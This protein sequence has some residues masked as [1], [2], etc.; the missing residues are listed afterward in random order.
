MICPFGTYSF[1]GSTTCIPC[2]AGYIC[3]EGST[4]PSPSTGECPAGGWCDGNQ[5]HPCESG[6][7]NNVSMPN[8]TIGQLRTRPEVCLDCLVGY[9]CTGPGT[10]N[11]FDYSCPAGHYCPVGTKFPTQFP[12]S[13]G[14]YN[15]NTTQTSLEAGCLPNQCP[16]GFYCPRGTVNPIICPQ[17]YYCPLGT[18]NGFQHACPLG[19]YGVFMYYENGT[20][21]Y[22]LSSVEDCIICPP[23]FYCPDGSGDNP[24]TAPVPCPP[25]T[26]NPFSGTG[27]PF[28]CLTCTPGFSCPQANQTNVTV[29]CDEGHYCPNGTVSSSQYPCPPGTFT[30]S[31]SLTSPEEC[32]ICPPGKSCGWATGL[33]VNIWLDCNPGHYCPS[34]T[35]SPDKFPCPPG[36]YT[37][38]SNLTA[39]EECSICPETKYCVGG[40]PQPDALCPPG[41]YCPEGTRLVHEF[42]CPATMY[43]PHFGK[44]QE[45][46]C[47]NCTQGHFCEEA[48]VRPLDCPSG[49]Y[50]PFGVNDNNETVGT[51]AGKQSDCLPCLAGHFCVNG[52]VNPRECGT[53][54]YTPVGQS[55]CI[56]CPSGH[57]CDSNTTTENDLQTAKLCP[58][59]KYCSGSLKTVDDALPCS[60]G[61]FCPE[62]IAYELPCPVGT[63]NPNTGASSLDDCLPCTAGFYCLENS[64]EVSGPCD[65]GFYCPVNITNGQSDKLIGSYGPQQVPCPQGTYQSNYSSA[66][67]GDCI[68][69]PAGSYCPVGSAEPLDCPRGYYCGEAVGEPEPCPIGTLGNRTGLMW[70]EDC[71]NCTKGRFCDAPGLP[72]P[73]GPCD[74][75]YLCYGGAYT[76][77]PTDGVTGEICPRGGYCPLGSFQSKP[78]PPGTFNNNS[79][80][81][82]FFDC[83]ECTPG[84]YCSDA[85]GPE[86]T[87]PC[88][89]GFYCTGG[90]QTARQHVAEPGFFAPSGSANQVSCPL[91]TY[92]PFW[93]ASKCLDCAVGHYCPNVSMTEPFKCPVGH[94][95]PEGTEEPQRCPPGTYSGVLLLA[96]ADN[97]TKC[98]A[99][100]F[101]QSGG[102]AAPEG[103][104][105][106]GHICRGGSITATP[107]VTPDTP[108]ELHINDICSPGFYCPNGTSFEVPCP[109]GTYSEAHALYNKTQCKPCLPGFYCPKSNMSVEGDL[110][111]CDPGF[112]CTLGSSVSRPLDGITGDI[113]SPG[114]YCPLGSA[115][116]LICP[117][118]TYANDSGL[119][120]CLICPEGLYCIADVID[121][122]PCPIGY[123][124]GEQTG[125]NY[126]PCPSGT[127]GATDSLVRETDCTICPGGMYCEFPAQ[128][129]TTGECD[130]GFWCREGARSARPP[131]HVEGHYGVCPAGYY[132]LQGSVGPEPCHPGF[133][134]PS[135]QKTNADDCIACDSGRYCAEGNQAEPTGNC[136]AGWY[137]SEGSSESQPGNFAFNE[138]SGDEEVVINVEYGGRCPLGFYCPEGSS[139]PLQCLPGTYSSR[140]GNEECIECPGGY[141]CPGETV[142]P[143]D[144]PCP[145]GYYCLNGTNTSTQYP[146]PV[147][148]FN[149]LTTRSSSRDCVTCTPG[150]YCQT[151][152]LSYPT[153]EC[154]GGVY[155]PAG[156]SSPTGRTCRAGRYCPPRSSEERPCIA[157]QFC[158]GNGN[159]APTGN[160][161][162]GYYCVEGSRSSRPSNGHC[163][164]GSYCPEGS[165][166]PTPCPPGTFA[167]ETLNQN[168][169]DCNTCLQG[170][171]CSGYDNTDVDGPCTEGYYCPPGQTQAAPNEF[172]CP[173]GHFCLQQ[174]SEPVR[175][176]SGYYQNETGQ[177]SCRKC[178]SGYY[179]DNS[180]EPI[181]FYGEFICPPGYYCEEGTEY[182]TQHPCPVGTFSNKTGL[183]HRLQCADCSGGHY[184]GQSGL[185]S[186]EGKCSA[187]FYC[188]FGQEVIAP[189]ANPC[190]PGNYC[191]E[192]SPSEIPCP[193]GTYNPGYQLTAESECIDCPPGKYCAHSGLF[194]YTGPCAEGYYC[195]NGSR[196]LQAEWQLCPSGSYCPLGSPDPIPC[197]NGTFSNTSGLRSEAD[198][199]SCLA[200]LFCIGT[201]LTEPSGKCMAGYYC[202]VHTNVSQPIENPCPPGHFCP[203]G[204]PEPIPCRHGE[205]QPNS[206]QPSCNP[207]PAGFYCTNAVSKPFECPSGYYCPEGTGNEYLPCLR[208]TFNNET[209]GSNITACKPCLGGHYCD[210]EGLSA[211][212]GK[213]NPGYFCRYGSDRPQPTVSDELDFVYVDNETC[214]MIDGRP[215]GDSG[216]CPVGHYCPVGTTEP[217]PC[218][219]GNY[220][221]SEGNSICDHCP[222]GYYCTEGSSAYDDKPCPTGYYC[223]FGTEY[224]KQYSCPRG[225]FNDQ[226]YGQSLLNCKPCTSGDFCAS[227]GLSNT[228]GLC[229]EGHYCQGSATISN[230]RNLET[231]GGKRCVPGT[232]CPSGSGAPSHCDPGYYCLTDGLAAPTNRCQA[233]FYCTLS[234]AIPNPTNNVTGNEC[235]KGHYCPEGSSRPLACPLGTFYNSFG[236]TQ[237]EDCISC[238]SGQFC[239]QPGLSL[240]TGFCDEGFYCPQGATNARNVSC[241]QGYFC[242]RGSS[243]PVRCP[244]GTYQDVLEQSLC[245]TCPEGYYCDN[246]ILGREEGII[247]YEPPQPCVLG[248]YCPNGTRFDTEYPCPR[249]TFGN[250]TKL[251]AV[252]H[253]RQCLAGQRC[254][255]SGL[256]EPT[257]FCE[258]G[259]FCKFG[260]KSPT[261]RQGNGA[262]ICP[263]GHYCVQGTIEPDK[264]P[265]GTFNPSKGLKMKSQCLNCT[266]GH[267]CGVHGISNVTGDCEAGYYCDSGATHPRWKYCPAGFFCPNGSADPIAC[268]TGTF[269]P[270][271]KQTEESDCRPCLGGFY[272]NS[273]GQSNV[274]G[275]CSPGFYCPAES[276]ARQP[277]GRE[278][279]VGMYCPEGSAVE[280]SCLAGT[281]TNRSQQHECEVCPRGYYCL[282]VQPHNASSAYQLCPRGYYCE[283]GTGLDWRPCPAGTYSDVFGLFAEWECTDCD[284]GEACERVGLTS[285]TSKCSSGYYCVSGVDRPNPTPSSEF[286]NSTDICPSLGEHSGIGG[287]CPPGH[288]CP[289]GSA[290]PLSCPAGTYNSLI[291]QAN[292][293]QCPQGYYCPENSTDYIDKPCPVGHYCLESTEYSTQY[294]CPKGTFNPS[295]RQ[296]NDSGCVPCSPGKFCSQE[297]LKEPSSNCSAG[298]YCESGAS[299][300]NTTTLGGRCPAGYYC[301]EGSGAP[302]PCPGGQY[303]QF[304]GFNM[305]TGNCSAGYVCHAKAISATPVDGM[306]GEPCP[307]GF[308]CPNGSAHAIPCPTGTYSSGLYNQETTD[309]DLCDPGKYCGGYNLTSPSGNCSAGYFCP[310]GSDTKSPSQYICPVGHFCVSG[311]RQPQRCPSG[312]YQ[313]EANKDACNVCPL[314]FFCDNR[315]RVVSL[316]TSVCPPGYYCP[317]G[318]KYFLDNPCPPGTYGNVSGLYAAEQCVSCD[319]GYLCPEE[320][321]TYP[322]QLCTIGYFCR[323]KANSSSPRQGDDANI[324]PKGR[325]CPEG[326]GEPLLCP[327]GT[328]NSLTGLG[329]DSECTLCT[330]GSHCSEPGLSSVSGQC[331]AG[332]YCPTGSSNVTAIIC[333]AGYFCTAG[334]PKPLPCPRGTYSPVEG[335]TSVGSCTQCKAGMYCDRTNL[336]A[337]TGACSPGYHC[338]PGQK[339]P[340]PVL[341]NCTVG[342]YCP[343]ET[344]YPLPCSNGTY[345]DHELASEC[346]VCPSGWYCVDGLLTDR[347]PPGSYC[348]QGTGFNW[349]PCPPGTYRNQSGAA[350]VDDCSPCDGGFYCHDYNQVSPSG[351]CHQG[352]Y[353]EFGVDRPDPSGYNSDGNNTVA[354]P[355]EGE[356]TGIGGPCTLGHYCP[357]GSAVPLSCP[358]GTFSN[359]TGLAKCLSCPSGFYCPGGTIFYEDYPCHEGY[360]CLTNTTR[361]NEYPCSEGHYNNRSRR[362]SQSD[363]LACPP[364]R[365][366]EGQGLSIPSGYC[367][368][369][370]YCSGM[371]SSATPSNF[372]GTGGPCQ[373]GFYC[374]KGSSYPFPCTPGS[375]CLTQ[376]LSE[377]TGL[378]TSSYYCTNSSVVANPVDGITGDICPAGHYCPNGTKVPFKCPHGTYANTTGNSKRSHCKDCPLGYYCNGLGLENP[379]GKCN[380]G[381]YCP[382]GQSHHSPAEY[383]CHLGHY[384][385]AGSSSPI[386]CDSGYYQ[387]EKKQAVCKQCPAGFFCDKRIEPVVFYNTSDCP[388][389]YFCPAGTNYSIEHPCPIGTFSNRTNLEDFSQCLQCSPGHY[390][391]TPGIT[392]PTAFCDPGYYCVQGAKSSRPTQAVDE[393]D[394]CPVGKYCPLGTATPQLCPTGKYSNETGLT[395]YDDCHVCDAGYYCDKMGLTTPAGQCN[396]GYFCRNGSTSSQQEICTEGHY[397][398]EGTSDP[399][400]CPTGT[401]SPTKGLANSS[402]C[403]PCTPGYYCASTGLIFPSGPCEAGY[404][405]PEGS[406]HSR[407]IICSEGHFCTLNSSEPL[408]C[409]YGT[410]MNHTGALQCDICPAGWYCFEGLTTVR[411]PAGFYCPEGTGFDWQPCTRGTY[412]N[413]E[414]LSAPEECKQCDGGSYCANLNATAPTGYC[415]A[416]YYCEYGVD[417]P[418]PNG[419]NY[420]STDTSFANTSCSNHGSQTGLGSLCPLGHFCPTN[421]TYPIPCPNGS[422]ADA[423]GMS[424]CKVCP[425]GY[426]C[427]RKS[428]KFKDKPCPVGHYCLRGTGN[429]YQYPCPAGTFSNKTK[430]RDVA[431]CINC[432]SGMYCQYDGLSKPTGLCSGG[433]FCLGGSA[434]PTPSTIDE[435]G[436]ECQVGQFCPEGSALYVPCTG[437]YYCDSPQLSKPTGGCAEGYYCSQGAESSTPTNG[438]TGDVCPPGSYCPVNSTAPLKCPIGTYSNASGNSD[439]SDCQPCSLGYFCGDNGL[440]EPSGSCAAGYFCPEGQTV[441]QPEMYVCPH[442]HHCPAGSAEAVRCEPGEYQDEIGQS[443]CKSCPAGFYCNNTE[444]GVIY[445]QL[446]PCVAGYYCPIG[447]KYVTQ[448]ACPVGTYSDRIGLNASKYCTPCSSGLYCD[449][450]GL[451]QPVDLCHAG[452]FCSKGAKRPNPVQGNDANICPV[453]HFCINGTTTPEPCPPGTFSNM[454]GLQDATECSDCI[455]GKYCGTSGLTEPTGKCSP[456]FYC[457]SGSISNESAICPAGSFCG[458]GTHHPEGCPSGNYSVTSGLSVSSEC[459]K[460]QAGQYCNS[461]GLT[462]PS[463]LC[464]AGYY[465][466]E[467]QIIPTP[468]GFECRIGHYCPEGTPEPIPCS[469]GTYTNQTLTS[470]C[471]ICLEGWY[472]TEG[473]LTGMCPRGYYCPRGTGYDWKPCPV[474]TYSNEVGLS[475]EHE[476]KACDGGKYCDKL[477]ATNY[478]GDCHAGFYCLYGMDRARPTNQSVENGTDLMCTYGQAG[479]GGV[480]PVAH[481][482]P[483]GSTTPIPCLP[484]TYSPVK[485]LSKCLI[486]PAGYYCLAGSETFRTQSCPE[487]HFCPVG[488]KNPHANPCRKG[489]YYNLTK[490]RNESNCIPCPGGEYCDS[491]GLAKPTGLCSEGWYCTGG[492]WSSMPN[493]TIEGGGYCIAGEFCPEGSDHPI[494]CTGGHYC[495]QSYLSNPTD[496]CNAGYYCRLGAK[497]PNPVNGA[498]GDKCSPGYFCPLGSEIETPCPPGTFSNASSNTDGSDCVNCTSGMFCSDYGLTEP[499]GKCSAGYYC[500]DGQRRSDPTEYTCPVGHF[501]L[502]GSSSFQR[503]PL[504]TF[505]N[506]TGQS[507]CLTCP[508]GYFC[509]TTISTVINFE[510]SLCPPGY[511]CPPGTRR[512]HEH[513]C[514]SGTYANESG[515]IDCLTCNGGYYCEQIGLKE[516]EALCSGGYFCK[517][518]ANRSEPRQ[519]PDADVCPAG[520]YCPVGNIVPTKCPLGTYNPYVNKD[521]ESDCLDCPPGYYCGQTGLVTFTTPCQEGYYCNGSAYRGDWEICPAG[522]FCPTQTGL[523]QP[524]PPGSFSPK[525]GLSNETECTL[526]TRGFYCNGGQ[527]TKTGPCH[528]GYYCPVGSS[529]SR[530]MNHVCPRG[531]H[532]PEGSAEPKPCSPGTFTNSTGQAVCTTCPDGFYCVPVEVG[533]TGDPY[534]ICPQ[535][536]YCPAGTG[537]NWISCPVGTYSNQFG[538][539]EEK[540]CTPCDSSMYCDK[541]GQTNV[542]GPCNPG[543]YCWRAATSGSPTSQN[544]TKAEEF[545]FSGGNETV[546]C[547]YH[548]EVA[549]PCSVGHY[550]PEGTDYPLRCPAGWFANNTHMESCHACPGG[551]YCLEGAS[552]FADNI[553]PSGHYCPE[554]TRRDTEFKCP[555]G[556]FNS[557]SGSVDISSCVNCTPGMYCEGEGLSY[558]TDS[559]PEGWYCSLGASQP[560]TTTHGG[561]CQKGEFCLEGSYQ[562]TPCTPGFYCD[563]PF[564]GNVT[565][566]CDAGYFCN[567]SAFSPRPTD[568]TGGECPVGQYCEVGSALPHPC[569]E[570]FYLNSTGHQ[571]GSDCLECKSGSYC[572]RPGL[573]VPT[574]PC[575]PGYYCPPRQVSPFAYNCTPGHFCP[576]GSAAPRRCFSGTYQNEAGQAACKECP[577]GYYCD[578]TQSPVVYY[579]NTECPAG[580]YCPNGTQYAN[581]FACPN[582]TYNPITGRWKEEQCVLCDPKRYCPRL[583][584]SSSYDLCSEGYYCKKGAK[585]ST[586]LQGVDADICPAGH[587]CPLGTDEPIPCPKGTFSNQIGLFSESNCVNCTAGDYCGEMRLTNTSGLCAAGFYCPEGSIQSTQEE[588]F[589][590]HFCPQGSVYPEPCPPGT[591]SN[592]THLTDAQDCQPCTPGTYCETY[593][594]LKPTGLCSSGFYCPEGMN[595]SQPSEYECPVGLHCPEGSATPKQCQA[596][597]YTAIVG[598]SMCM[599]CSAGFYCLPVTSENH[600]LNHL[601][602][603]PGHYCPA[604]TGL[605]WRPCPAGTY[606]NETGLSRSKDCTPCEAGWYC[607]F[608]G[609]TGPTGLCWGGYYCQSGVSRPNPEERSENSTCSEY[610]SLGAICPAGTFC[611]NGSVSPTSCE[612]GTYNDELGQNRCKQC[613][614]GYYCNVGTVSY[615]PY[616]CPEGHYCLAGTKDAYQFKC[617]NGTYNPVVRAE[618][619]SA[620]LPCTPG[621][622]CEGLGL[623]EPTGNCSEG[624]YCSGGSD[625]PMTTTHGG[626]CQPGFYCPSMSSSLVPCDPGYYCHRSS[627]SQPTGKCASGYYCSSGASTDMPSDETG[628]ICPRGHYCNEGSIRPQQCPQGYFLNSTGGNSS[629][630]CTPCIP[631]SFCNQPGLAVPAGQCSPGYFCP[632]GQE[633][634]TPERFVCSPGFKCPFG[635]SYQ[636]PCPAGYYQDEPSQSECK[637]C[638]SGFY[639]DDAIEPVVYPQ[640]FTCPRGYYCPPGTRYSTEYPCP[641]GYFNDIEGRKALNECTPCTGGDVC[642][643]QGLVSPN[644]SCAAGY[645]CRAFANQTTPELGDHANICPAGFYCP[646][647]TDSPEPCPQGTFSPTPGLH[648]KSQCLPCRAGKFCENVNM[649]D[650]SGNCAENYYCPIGSSRPDA[651]ICSPGSFCPEGSAIPTPCSAGT[652][653]NATGLGSESQ[654]SPCTPGLYCAQSGLTKPTGDCDEGFYCPEGMNVSAPAEF[655][656]PFGMHC[657]R[658]S[659]EPRQCAAGTFTSNAGSAACVQ[660][661]ARFYCLPVVRENST[662]NQ[663][664][665]P[666]GYYCPTG[667]GLDWH[668]CPAGTYSNETG[669][670][671]EDECRPCTP[672]H[673]CAT[674]GL[675]KPTGL[676]YGG[677]Y[678]VQAIAI[679]N[680]A[681]TNAT[682]LIVESEREGSGNISSLCGLYPSIGDICPV[683]HYCPNGT[684]TPIQCANGTYSDTEGQSECLLCPTGYYCLEGSVTYLDTPCPTGYYCPDGTTNPFEY[685]CSQGTFNNLTHQGD[686]MSCTDCTP[687]MYCPYRGMDKPIGPCSAGWF[688]SGGASESRPSA[689]FGGECQPGEY[690]PE[691]SFEPVNCEDGMYCNQSGL[692]TPTGLCDPGYYCNNGSSTAQQNLCPTGHYCTR[693]SISPEACPR[694]TS[695]NTEGNRDIADCNE[696]PAGLFCNRYGLSVPSGPCSEGFYCPQRQVLPQP[697]DYPCPK[698]HYCPEGSPAP[699]RCESGYYQDDLQASLCKVCEPGFYCD[700]RFEPVVI[701]EANSTCPPGY[702]CPAGTRYAYEYPCLEGTFSNITGLMTES[703]CSNCTAGSHCSRKGLTAP[704]GPCTAG[705]YCSGRNTVSNPTDGRCPAGHYCPEGSV[706]PTPCKQGT[707]SAKELNT[708]QDNCTACS[709]GFYC[710]GNG[711][712]VSQTPCQAGFICVGGAFAPNP[713]DNVTGYICPVGHY[714]LEGAVN[715]DLCENGTF[716]NQTGLGSCFEC[717]HRFT[718]PTKG[719]I[720]PTTCPPG[721]FCKNGTKSLYGEPCPP[722]TYSDVEGLAYEAECL[723]CPPGKYCATPG[724][725][726]PTGD[727]SAGYLC[728]GGASNA[729]PSLCPPGHFCENGTTN[730]SQCPEGT[731]APNAGLASEEDCLACPPGMFCNGRGLTKATGPCAGGY[732]CPEM[733]HVVTDK[734][735]DYICPAGFYCPQQSPY[736]LACPP[737]NYS[738]NGS[739]FCDQCPEGKFCQWNEI[740]PVDCPPYSYCPAGTGYPLPCPPGYYTKNDTTGL[741][742]ASQCLPCLPGNYCLVGVISGPCYAGY[743]CYNGS[744]TPTPDGVN[745]TGG[746]LCPLGFYCPLGTVEPQLCPPNL[747]IL[748]RGADSIADCETCPPGYICPAESAKAQDCPPG[749][750]CPFNESKQ[751]CPPTTFSMSVR[752]QN[753]S[754]CLPCPAGY[755]CLDEGMPT[756]E[757]GPCPVGYYCEEAVYVPEPCPP[758]TFRNSTGAEN[759]TDCELCPAGRYCP[760]VNGTT[761]GYH[762][763]EGTYCPLGSSLYRACQAGY[764]CNEAK[765]QLPCPGGFFCPNSSSMPTPC[766][767]GHYCSGYTCNDS[768]IEAG[769]IEPIICPEG[770]WSSENSTR[771]TFENTCFICPSGHYCNHPQRLN[772]TICR[773]GVVCHEGATTDEPTANGTAY[774]YARTG[775]YVCPPG[776]YCPSKSSYPRACRRGHYQAG[777]GK[778]G[779]ADCIPCETNHY[780]NG[781]GASHCYFCGSDAFAVGRGNYNCTC[782]GEGREFQV[783]IRLCRFRILSLYCMCIS[784]S[785]SQVTGLVR[786]NLV[787]R[788]GRDVRR[789]AFGSY[790]TCVQKVACAIRTENVVR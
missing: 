301:P 510:E 87:G 614:S 58:P 722:G 488:T 498:T 215:F 30:G 190:N 537:A 71:T 271:E 256:I 549:G 201:G 750:Y 242:D 299:V 72:G 362:Q 415:Q 773:A 482:C 383:A 460:C 666:G 519:G 469:N 184:C 421:S 109:P 165:A 438:L 311:S 153:S 596:G 730:A 317:L 644:A 672:G 10:I 326:S 159:S 69:C 233:G 701:F 298:W 361:W 377:P 652:F 747:V 763:P 192:G 343:E 724:L 608:P 250:E 706:D 609:Q 54:L 785:C 210:E 610:P 546:V 695:L 511:F 766:P 175:C 64:T 418:D 668:P 319:A 14:T 387:D 598:A 394:I 147:G 239:N 554:R 369:G 186:P 764:Y 3:T 581:Q 710:T 213:C 711:A 141:Y 716:S 374:P 573:S 638:P 420:N 571:S 479:E 745:Y 202:P 200:G 110:P 458:K 597:T 700:S 602:C 366:C 607:E 272:C 444:N 726:S 294:P 445:Y 416:G 673:Y 274:T 751:A 98:P 217:I 432:T 228:S 203:L 106:G 182:A 300:P 288:Y 346:Y 263:T 544:F 260:A 155:C 595:N 39:P 302:T 506:S 588:C 157:G 49:T 474:G 435:G 25:G 131:D 130:S 348:P 169:S 115:V 454:T 324:C 601:L 729:G 675:T 715:P 77:T 337:P 247:P 464:S 20:E 525:M 516:P 685:A 640:N 225:F 658:G 389:G 545:E 341:Y 574:G 399:K 318:T 46:D 732:Y 47:V 356:Q 787:M 347:C 441:A 246:T 780:G 376:M 21:P 489:T 523:P 53:G 674:P 654:C 282:P 590:G 179:C 268:P 477:A 258:P 565:G 557:L 285:P 604:G 478:T 108:E 74:P 538:L 579:N 172:V 473:V 344:A 220:S 5:F 398:S 96:S 372:T 587:Y 135:V 33:A 207:C 748:D 663:R 540:Q 692:A 742:S 42:P 48:T 442:G 431:D 55:A 249:G 611:T 281:F 533:Y 664:L 338:P 552:N 204:T 703:Q 655:L 257:G 146:C 649:T 475:D 397:C 61:Y 490:A 117:D 404:Y 125:A 705:Y 392:E 790:T 683:G 280:Q 563:R 353:C 150:F 279:S 95:C 373:E 524:C 170:F 419:D 79:E 532:C 738:R 80:S 408:P 363:C 755:W 731:I 367:D 550:C 219:A 78:C 562:P 75:G 244:S 462:A 471:Y 440:T 384:C 449:R 485:Q 331:R 556:T 437:G 725:D 127:Y 297:G 2:D 162:A 553:C 152:G 665:C 746:E 88:D 303:C 433:W 527:I 40:K 140:S 423:I 417:R 541:E 679:P 52:T 43:N 396:P 542:T 224:D 428:L 492:S 101:C 227:E 310:E 283:E 753:R 688:C 712:A 350:A 336:T 690:C 786:V 662:L 161:S 656:C 382:G 189:P 669:L 500:P 699:I 778:T 36:T 646:E 530:P 333:P 427:P 689:P 359:V 776:Y 529:V 568:S 68:D 681:V 378:C 278:C 767:Q 586:P 636:Q 757:T 265:Q 129:N 468:T 718:C 720:N 364:G 633:L 240:P 342:H 41:Y 119:V 466:P 91:G 325:Y 149:N 457:L 425:S 414:G 293:S 238:V 680:P 316:N 309:C 380:P 354:C 126:K 57:F 429:A 762:C 334:L 779:I 495:D 676:C 531:L 218:P 513:P 405:C 480:C 132:C 196:A 388:V 65:P 266:G 461:T 412:S 90:A 393:A 756:Y 439:L 754:T 566:P 592:V 70:I 451:T 593:G 29:P 73:R 320:G 534:E 536:F 717:P 497:I 231:E 580:Y 375:F 517:R 740:V 714:C 526:C 158:S 208:G 345:A 85:R 66:V 522:Y 166:S 578:T 643:H 761:E 788:K 386:R 559:C 136:S 349:M 103:N 768:L 472:C 518:G 284:G 491:A 734:P 736:P 777:E 624:W 642:D 296:V 269:S 381:Y 456:G 241:P 173:V 647:G 443:S 561:F 205:Y 653:S 82:N 430:R 151:K 177:S 235:P 26:Y 618:G 245:K 304:P 515:L 667:T 329:D 594:L 569:P 628:N 494:P 660:C 539:F 236:N 23:G 253:C 741:A 6:K 697:P 409:G 687:G 45:S 264:C 410:F 291:R 564:L 335:I 191:P 93:N 7:Y 92:N 307:A 59:G 44:S 702:Y 156:E 446:S 391:D 575:A 521:D 160:C 116:E 651:V 400:G 97:C 187:G 620:C 277:A 617:F 128:S 459:T 719:I 86:P 682:D 528:P 168:E 612:A 505:Q 600:T 639:C 352:F 328:F 295:V 276:V 635:S 585:S 229:D 12:C 465:C 121:P 453:G 167:N 452:Y 124:C 267:F 448:F 765:T 154:P 176:P 230:P 648:N 577:E 616:T 774:G 789:T 351:P 174:S 407:Q 163:P 214:V 455:A 512:Q 463:G 67:E 621:K 659:S 543:Y 771:D 142:N 275:L 481:Q 15:M 308:Y 9:Y 696:C 34:G 50:M 504:G 327:I 634:S 671:V 390:C 16:E 713:N 139:L 520:H 144:Y 94:Y 781:T 775:S 496:K 631:G 401:F 114:H 358:A 693:G 691:G 261:P 599:T 694:G 551:Y 365:Y 645:Y 709:P 35:P 502:N 661:P 583:G 509:D 727:C 493:S 572:D 657:S 312:F 178:T 547:R 486:C 514:P 60:E 209:G 606:S 567:G 615:I 118:G 501:C 576:G 38:E 411:C 603:P 323:Q 81:V 759:I 371:A 133:Y 340:T 723:P 582:G 721:Y 470:E 252:F 555:E 8:E 123:F 678:C 314:G 613:P 684:T 226:L 630:D 677:Y 32:T 13:D 216:L 206:R 728:V 782:T 102:L 447:T 185:D 232:Y 273:E 629:S 406:S 113:C 112:F 784:F 148:K 627:L 413:E 84:F 739:S 145:N 708:A 62:G 105:H 426:Y 626:Q 434:T 503:C 591:F 111:K 641:A 704:V 570:G 589:K 535:G 254:N 306:T 22:G 476:C 507:S 769:A 315:I 193:R 743:I 402:Q 122:Q 436:R 370:W 195:Q 783:S 368:E 100:K 270:D 305:P 508:A 83:F 107:V 194:N 171:Y 4:S 752:A 403:T 11:P 63:F 212:S 733:A 56:E 321:L 89:P 188:P 134:Q 243:F 37:P 199:T 76:S 28:N 198:C 484:G 450:E 1:N 287:E 735:S 197:P 322:T 584:A 686:W 548:E 292:C 737:G 605:N 27:H 632:G 772:Y 143:F 379:S 18:G 698:G 339:S 181:E 290:Y 24:A 183:S 259:Y 222:A 558:P 31:R 424:Y 422:Y 164:A 355:V 120:E 483:R 221:G 251:Y 289:V 637:L 749:F 104:C 262:D 234:A 137:C 744:S 625:K 286:E 211:P 385:P 255:G 560:Q 467:G 395:S 332:Y 770:Y 622:Y 707:S 330:A 650:V 248:H 19:M 51:P 313:D 670:A 138:S 360:Y 17:G 357:S 180:L 223:P 758:G 619:P 237:E 99:G 760:D 499:S 623:Y 487:G